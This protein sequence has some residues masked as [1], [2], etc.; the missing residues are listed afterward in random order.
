MNS[1]PSA[2]N[3]RQPV[4]TVLNNGVGNGVLEVIIQTPATDASAVTNGAAFPHTTPDR[5]Y[6]ST[7]AVRGGLV[8]LWPS[9]SDSGL[10]LDFFG[11]TLDSIRTF[12]AVSQRTVGKLDRFQ[13]KPIG[14]VSLDEDSISRFRTGYRAL[15]GS[16]QDDA[17]YESI[18]ERRRFSGMEHWL[19]LFHE[20][21]ANILDFVPL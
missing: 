19:P 10:R 18:S 17:L 4:G 11:D 21:L 7:F 3:I 14:E 15:F 13:L 5:P 16:T 1:A 9:G 20:T 2:P 12:E 8:D 6:L